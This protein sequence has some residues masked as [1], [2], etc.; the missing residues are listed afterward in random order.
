MSKTFLTVWVGQFV[1]RIGTA[2]TRFALLIWAYQL[3]GSATTVALLG[4]FSFLPIILISPIAGVWVDRLDRRKVMIWTDLGAGLMT[5]VMLLLVQ[6][7]QLQIWHLYLAEAL[8]GAFEAFQIP[9]YTA[10]SST[11]VSKDHYARA[12][13]LRAMADAGAQVIAPF[14]AGLLLLWLGISSVMMIDIVTFLAAIGT[15]IF[16]RFPKMKRADEG[17]TAVSTSSRQA[18][19][20][21]AKFNQEIQV[22]FRFIWQRRGLL[23][24]L[25]IFTGLNFF[26]SITYLSI[27]PAMVLARS[28][29]SGGEL[30]LASVQ[31]TL[32]AAGVLGGLIMVAWGGTKRKVHGVLAGAAVSFLFGDLLFAIGQSLPIWLIA[33]AASAIFIPIILSSNQTIWQAKVPL[34]LQGRVFSVAAMVRQS[35]MPI[36]YLIGGVLADQ[37]LEPAMMPSGSLALSLGWLVGTGSGSG[38][39]LMFLATAVLGCMMS[40]SGYLFPAI[41]HVET[42]LPDHDFQN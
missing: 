16:V 24:L 20:P 13:G 37:W 33:S 38:M 25:L 27:L 10:A 19:S 9:A 36:G 39:A 17:E 28:G 3:T 31:G 34:E 15:L 30:A 40:L 32:G 2:M 1:S 23:G 22:G 11:L 42:D 18:V 6:I 41:R 7:G 5:I 26:A 14:A 35:L 29:S 8:A 4:F 12:N 21:F